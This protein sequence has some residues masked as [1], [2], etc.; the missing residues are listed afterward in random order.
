MTADFRF[1]GPVGVRDDFW[2]FIFISFG[3]GWWLGKAASF[4]NQH[5]VDMD[6]F[7]GSMDL[8][9]EGTDEGDPL[10]VEK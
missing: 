4:C 7:T 2:H 5:G 6:D 9:R 10:C 8:V 1:G 3:L